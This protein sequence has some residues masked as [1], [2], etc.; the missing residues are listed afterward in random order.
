MEV[1]FE[2]SALYANISLFE[3]KKKHIQIYGG[4]IVS[5]VVILNTPI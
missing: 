2:H 1:R 4:L 3:K 5:K